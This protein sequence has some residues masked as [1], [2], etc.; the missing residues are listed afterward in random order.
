MV[1]SSS[2]Q[3]CRNVTILYIVSSERCRQNS[4]STLKLVFWMRMRLSEARTS[5]KFWSGKS[6]PCTMRII[7]I[8]C[9]TCRRM[10]SKLAENSISRTSPSPNEQRHSPVSRPLIWSKPIFCSYVC[11]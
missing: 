1:L 2:E 9:F 8:V 11:G 3:R 7:S 4:S 6:S 10:L 5:K